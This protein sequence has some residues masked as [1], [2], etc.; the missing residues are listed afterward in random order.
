[1]NA[2]A[3]LALLTPASASHQQAMAIVDANR[4]RPIHSY[5]TVI[6]EGQGV[7]TC[8]FNVCRHDGDIEDL[9]V[10]SAEG[11]DITKY[12]MEEQV[13]DLEWRCK[14]YNQAASLQSYW[15]SRIAA[16]QDPIREPDGSGV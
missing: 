15:E 3:N 12:L 9:I 16:S 6:G 8:L 5:Q 2:P 14:V 13:I 11:H 1:M 7:V 10:E 4:P